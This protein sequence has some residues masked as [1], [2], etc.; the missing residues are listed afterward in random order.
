MQDRGYIKWEPFN[1]VISDKVILN[2]LSNKRNIVEKPTLSE[3]QINYLN[4]YIFEAYT[5]HLKVNLYIYNNFKI[6]KLIGFINNIN[7]TKKYITF[8]KNH[9]FFNQILKITN[10]FEKSN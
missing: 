5:N 3:D 1:S 6:I 2:D 10:F 8:N 7:I 4:D 9:I